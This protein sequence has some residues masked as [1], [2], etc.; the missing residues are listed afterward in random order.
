M[1]LA[2]I[3][4]FVTALALISILT[5][6][7][8]RLERIA[9]STS[10]VNTSKSDWI[11]VAKALDLEM[12]PWTTA[13]KASARGTVGGHWVSVEQLESGIE[14]VVNYRSGLDSFAATQPN[15]SERNDDR[16]VTGDDLFDS[17]VE[18]SSRAPEQ[19]RDYLTPARR[20]ALLWLQSAFT[21]GEIDQEMLDVTFTQ[22]SWQPGQL[23]S[24]IEL[25]VDVA[26]IMEA[27]EK[28]FMA[29]PGV[30]LETDGGEDAVVWGPRLVSDDAAH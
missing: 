22:T 7:E 30:A 26:E 6:A 9:K 19:V 4:I 11:A 21:L 15:P 16:F 24:N 29:P 12:S 25:V 23:V 5:V 14:I 17:Q 8:M 3:A 28:V 13:A 20:N 18:V 2:L 27:G 10:S 1:T